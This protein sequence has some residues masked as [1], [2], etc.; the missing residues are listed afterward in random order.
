MLHR[1]PRSSRLFICS[2]LSLSSLQVLFLYGRYLSTLST[3]SMNVGC[4]REL[5]FTSVGSIIQ[6]HLFFKD[7]H[8]I[9]TFQF[10]LCSYDVIIYIYIST[11][12]NVLISGRAAERKKN[13]IP[14]RLNF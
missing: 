13:R 6:L 14:T 12:M 9:L 3:Y 7:I 1:V 11:N 8:V 10:N 2:G 4:T 5:T